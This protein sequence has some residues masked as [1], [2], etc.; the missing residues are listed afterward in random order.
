MQRRSIDRTTTGA[1]RD[2][3]TA[4]KVHG[5]GQTAEDWREIAKERLGMAKDEVDVGW[6][7]ERE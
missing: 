2:V 1:E 7:V 4:F 6:W 3:K 5:H